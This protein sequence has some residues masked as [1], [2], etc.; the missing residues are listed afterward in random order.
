M[1]THKTYPKYNPLRPGDP[2][3]NLSLTSTRNIRNET[4][5]QN[6]DLILFDPSITTKTSLGDCFRIFTDHDRISRHPAQRYYARGI[7]MCCHPLQIFTDGACFENGKKNARCGSGLWIED[8]DHRNQA[9]KDAGENQ[10]NQ[11]GEIAAVIKAAGAAYLFQPLVIL[12]DSKYV[13]DGLTK[14]LKCMGRPRVD[15]H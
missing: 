8:G 1:R 15:R 2:H 5:R 9:I 14:H 7:R 10:S 13:I 3:D 11:I 4:A 12:T 6:N